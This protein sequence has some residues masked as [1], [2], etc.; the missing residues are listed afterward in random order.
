MPPHDHTHA[1]E[2]IAPV[3]SGRHAGRRMRR[4]HARYVMLMDRALPAM[5]QRHMRAVAADYLADH[6]DCD[7]LVF[8]PASLMWRG[9]E[10]RGIRRQ[11]IRRRPMRAPD[12]QTLPASSTHDDSATDMIRLM[13]V[14][15]TL[16]ME[17][18]ASLRGVLFR[19][20]IIMRHDPAVVHAG[21]LD[22]AGMT[23]LTLRSLEQCSSVHCLPWETERA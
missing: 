19:S 17:G 8:V 3:M 23:M 20:G 4:S 16:L 5:A 2:L 1:D 22:A 21:G 14:N 13:T 10:S 6:R 18:R 9:L 7:L 15:G 11:P 12:S